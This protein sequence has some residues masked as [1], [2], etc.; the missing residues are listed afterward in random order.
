MPPAI[1]EARDQVVRWTKDFSRTLDYLESRGDL[2]VSKSAYYGYSLGAWD[3]LP[4]LGVERRLATA[5]LLTGGVPAVAPPPEVDP[6]NFLPRA[7]LPVLML[8]GRYDFIFPV[9]TSQ[10]PLFNLFATPAPDKRLVIFENAGHV[11]PRIELIREVL[12]WLDR[13]LGPVQR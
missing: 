5:I 8:G 4:I 1:N 13:Y 12:A 7:V 2:D 11:P 9:E 3:S 6:V 10:K